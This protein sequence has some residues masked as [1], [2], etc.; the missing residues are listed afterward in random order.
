[1][2]GG[3][4]LKKEMKVSGKETEILDWKYIKKAALLPGLLGEVPTQMVSHLYKLEI[5]FFREII[6]GK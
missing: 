2:G 6:A 4:E 1:M 5:L 3:K